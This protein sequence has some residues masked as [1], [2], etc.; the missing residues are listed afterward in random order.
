MDW[1]NPNKKEYGPGLDPVESETD[2]V[3]RGRFTKWLD[4]VLYRAKLKYLRKLSQEIVMI[5]LSLMKNMTRQMQRS[6]R[7]DI[8]RRKRQIKEI[9]SISADTA[10]EG[11]ERPLGWTNTIR[12][13]RSYIKRKPFVRTS[14]GVAVTWRTCFWQHI[15]RNCS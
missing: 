14:F 15:D 7:F 12:V 11:S 2:D 1:R 5:L 13:R 9:V 8:T 10:A 4:V 6:E 3:L